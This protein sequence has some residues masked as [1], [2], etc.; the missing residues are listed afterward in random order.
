MLHP[1]FANTTSVPNFPK[2][3]KLDVN[4]LTYELITRYLVWNIFFDMYRLQ[5]NLY[6][7]EVL[8]VKTIH[9]PIFQWRRYLLLYT[10]FYIVLGFSL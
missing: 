9:C 2:N 4:R 8:A 5:N 6:M 3:K 1:F 10:H 7:L